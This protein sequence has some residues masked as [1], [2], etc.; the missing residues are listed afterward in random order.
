MFKT[1]ATVALLA[2]FASANNTPIYG[3]YPGYTVGEG[4]TGI[5]I[6]V[7][8]DYLCSACQSENPVI[9]QLLKEE[10]LDGTVADQITVSYTPF[11]LPYHTHSYQVNQLVPYFM[12]LCEAD[13]TQCFNNSYRDYSYEMLSTVLS[14]KDTSKDDFIPWWSEQVATVFGLDAAD[15]EASYTSEIYNTDMSLRAMWKYAAAKGVHATPT[16]FVNGAYLD[17]VPFKVN[18]WM[19]LLNSIYDSQYSHPNQ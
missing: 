2:N 12:D 16:A 8:F 7:F 18:G 17:N 4:R 5:S 15:I 13:S 1:T 10:W 9:E 19:K 3:T 14:M 11:P 6:E